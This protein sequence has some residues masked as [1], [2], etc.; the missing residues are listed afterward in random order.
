MERAEATDLGPVALSGR[1]RVS[2][3]DL[4]YEALRDMIARGEYPPDTPLSEEALATRLGLSRTPLRQALGRLRFEHLVDRSPGGRL[5]VTPVSSAD[6]SDVFAVR[7]ALE[8]L[9]LQQ[10]V[11]LITDGDLAMLRSLL[12][13]MRSLSRSNP[14]AVGSY[15]GEFHATIYRVGGNQVNLALLG[16][17]QGRIDRYR[18]FSTAT[19]ARRTQNAVREHRLILQTLE[20]RDAAAAAAALHTHLQAAHRSVLAA[21]HQMNR[22][23]DLNGEGA[24]GSARAPE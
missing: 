12:A 23:T 22:S 3:E 21:L 1:R 16:Q 19:G 18:Y 7:L 8:Q 17:L 20:A 6:A 13:Q 24:N 4:A 10:A 15:G 14:D 5:F 11:P 2:A 9:A